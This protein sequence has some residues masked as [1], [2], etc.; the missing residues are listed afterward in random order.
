MSAS[1]P[2]PMS[3]AAAAAEALSRQLVLRLSPP[4]DCGNI[5]FVSNTHCGSQG[6]Q[7]RTIKPGENV[8]L[9]GD[10]NLGE[11]WLNFKFAVSGVSDDNEKITYSFEEIRDAYT[12]ARTLSPSREQ[13]ELSLI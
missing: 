10:P 3:A 13:Q 8:V 4:S 6:S 5:L 7:E 1:A 9:I 11:G 12:K 2:A